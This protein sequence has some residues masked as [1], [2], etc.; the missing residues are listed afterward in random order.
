VTSSTA[1][2]VAW[3]V[4]HRADVLRSA[5]QHASAL[6]AL[7]RG[8]FEA[9]YQHAS[10]ISPAGTLAAHVPQTLFVALDLVEAAVRSGRRVEAV[11]HVEAMQ[12]ADISRLS[13]HLALVARGAAAL[14]AV[15]HDS[16]VLLFERALGESDSELWPFEVARLRFGYGRLLRAVGA[17][18]DAKVQLVA[19]MDIFRRLGADPWVKQ[20]RAE[21]RVCLGG[22]EAD[23]RL[24]HDGLTAQ[25]AEVASLAAAGL[26]N[27]QIAERLHLSPRTVST[28]LYHV[29]PKL[30]I[31]NR[32]ALRDALSR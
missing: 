25:E 31:R 2:I 11:A 8:D 1:D 24:A 5:A 17:D 4:P 32:A 20:A 13:A 22:D 14:V 16:A 9:A 3:A 30:G 6:A 12:A 10:A 29:F 28:H 21:L 18:R 27:K 19:A 26:T 7:G 23:D 15:E